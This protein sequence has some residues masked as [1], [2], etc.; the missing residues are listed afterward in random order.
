MGGAPKARRRANPSLLRLHPAV[1]FYPPSAIIPLPA[2]PQD[3]II[4]TGASDGVPTHK[5]KEGSRC[6]VYSKR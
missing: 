3:R 2:S 1:S 4:S 5:M 6:T